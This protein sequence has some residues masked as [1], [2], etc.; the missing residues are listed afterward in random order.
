MNE[1]NVNLTKADAIFIPEDISENL[2]DYKEYN[3]GN[4]KHC[5]F[6]NRLFF[7]R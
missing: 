6:D 2:N 5:P 1:K 7:S 3:G 4:T